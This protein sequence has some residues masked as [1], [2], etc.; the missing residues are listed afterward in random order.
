MDINSIKIVNAQES[1]LPEIFELV[2]Q[3]ALYEKEPE[4]VTTSIAEYQK[5]FREGVFEVILA[6]YNEDTI[7][8]ALFYTT[9]STWK[10]RMIYLED[11][12][13]KE[14][15][16]GQGVGDLIFDHFI[17]ISKAKDAKLVK[18]QVLDWNTPAIKFYHKKNATIEKEWWNGKIIF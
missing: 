15:Y 5:C 1:D 4:S 7:G 13:V 8:M 6:K 3:L 16:R 17:D 9:F 11:F 14:S 10:G 2:K 12:I 18:W